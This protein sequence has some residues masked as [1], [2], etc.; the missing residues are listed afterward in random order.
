MLDDSQV[1]TGSQDLQSCQGFHRPCPFDHPRSYGR[2]LETIVSV[3]ETGTN[4]ILTLELCQ[5]PYD[6]LA[7]VQKV[8]IRMER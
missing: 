2:Y 3:F 5:P 4:E 7:L 1:R 6:L 8:S